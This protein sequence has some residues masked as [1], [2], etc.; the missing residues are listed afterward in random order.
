M[1]KKNI[2]PL[3]YRFATLQT[4][5]RKPMEYGEEAIRNSQFGLEHLYNQVRAL[6][7]GRGEI[8]KEFKEQFSQAI[9]DDLNMP[10]VL[11]IVQELLKSSIAAKNKLATVL[12]FDRIL[13][14]NLDQAGESEEI[15]AEVMKLAQGREGARQRRN[16][17]ESDRLRLVI[18][19]SGYMVED[20]K[21]GQRISKK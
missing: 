7:Q 4:H 20:K 17:A 6:G 13:G 16:W 9:N 18:E 2:N 8:N 14:L 11:A 5:Y 10:L 3:A 21:D 19:K 15:P 1:I 12:D